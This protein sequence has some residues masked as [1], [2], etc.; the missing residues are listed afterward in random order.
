MI[1]ADVRFRIPAYIEAATEKLTVTALRQNLFNVFATGEPVEIERHDKRLLLVTEQGAEC[2]QTLSPRNGAIHE[3]R[4]A[5]GLS[6]AAW[7]IS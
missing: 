4:H 7:H 5:A 1:Y 3:F 6:D 2:G